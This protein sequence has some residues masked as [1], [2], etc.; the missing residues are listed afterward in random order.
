MATS[1][2][3]TIGP[4]R[5]CFP[6]GLF[7]PNENGKY[8]LAVLLNK[9]TDKSAK[10]QLDAI[11]TAAVEGKWPN[12]DTRPRIPNPVKDCDEASSTD[13]GVPMAYKYPETEGHWMIRL[14]SSR[15]VTVFDKNPHNIVQDESRVYGGMWMN[16]FLN[17]YPWTF[18]HKNGV[19]FGLS[20]VQIARDDD[21]FGGLAPSPEAAGFQPIVDDNP[22]EAQ[23]APL[24][25]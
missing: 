6:R 17:A 20:S 3:I 21:A 13:E 16:I 2:Y 5:V 10:A 25:A 9:Q 18:K 23:P 19:S 7:C 11:A 4:H 8:T 15:P 14:T 22:V 12:A 24:W 1:E